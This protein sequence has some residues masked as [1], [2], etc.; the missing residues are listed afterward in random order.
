[1]T[2]RLSSAQCH[3]E[4]AP[5][6]P[7]GGLRVLTG[8]CLLVF[9]C[10]PK[11]ELIF[12]RL[13]DLQLKAQVSLLEESTV[14]LSVSV[15]KIMSAHLGLCSEACCFVQLQFTLFLFFCVFGNQTENGFPTQKCYWLFF[16][17]SIA[18]PENSGHLS[19]K[20]L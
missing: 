8:I 20:K 9:L 14:K 16:L 19:D 11:L 4:R 12:F 10:D 17:N 1:M 6:A 18:L 3:G 5:R 15:E 13:T 2:V 7:S